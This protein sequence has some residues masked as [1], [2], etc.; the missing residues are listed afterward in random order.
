[1]GWAVEEGADEDDAFPFNDNFWLGFTAREFS[2]VM[3]NSFHSRVVGLFLALGL[4]LT[5]RRS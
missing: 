4:A 2:N 3:G 1:M 5:E